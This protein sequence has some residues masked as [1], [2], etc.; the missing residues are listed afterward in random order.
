MLTRDL[1]VDTSN[2]PALAATLAALP[3]GQHELTAEW[4]DGHRVIRT[5]NPGFL[6]YAIEQQGYATVIGWRDEIEAS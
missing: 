1:L 4:V 5:S 2:P 3:G 6:R